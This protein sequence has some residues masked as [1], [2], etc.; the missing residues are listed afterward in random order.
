M[1]PER[2]LI[3]WMSQNKSFIIIRKQRHFLLE[4]RILGIDIHK[5]QNYNKKSK[6]RIQR[7]R[8]VDDRMRLHVTRSSLREM[9]KHSTNMIIEMLFQ[10]IYSSIRRL[11]LNK[12]FYISLMSINILNR[13]LFRLRLRLYESVACKIKNDDESIFYI[14]DLDKASRIFLVP[15]FKKKIP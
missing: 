15:T 14:P 7:S 9:G 6:S 2:N 4:Y 11:S 5:S 13:S 12:Y 8:R 10:S 1:T 3:R